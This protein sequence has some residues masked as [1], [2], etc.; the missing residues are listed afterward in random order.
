MPIWIG[1]PN[2]GFIANGDAR[3]RPGVY[4]VWVNS[5]AEGRIDFELLRDGSVRN[6]TEGQI[7]APCG[8]YRNPPCNRVQTEELEPGSSGGRPSTSLR[9]NG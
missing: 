6:F 4:G 3:L 7:E 2:A 5:N 1:G 8:A 9:T